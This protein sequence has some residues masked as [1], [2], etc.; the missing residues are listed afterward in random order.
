LLF[1]HL[2]LLLLLLKPQIA[3]FHVEIFYHLKMST[4]LKPAIARISDECMH[5]RENQKR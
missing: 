1:F 4:K 2:I 5:A 3:V